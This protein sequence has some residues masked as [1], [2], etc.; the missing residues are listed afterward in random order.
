MNLKTMTVRELIEQL[1]EVVDWD[2]DVQIWLPGSR[3]RVSA[4]LHYTKRG[5][6][7][8]PVLIEGNVEEGSAL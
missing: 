7:D 1:S 4:L 3:I 2:R 5:K 6:K 8:E